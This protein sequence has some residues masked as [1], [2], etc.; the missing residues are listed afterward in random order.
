MLVHQRVEK[1]SCN[2]I[3]PHGQ[4]MLGVVWALNL[5]QMGTTLYAA[6]SRAMRRWRWG[7][8]GV[9][10]GKIPMVR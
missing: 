2:L 5:A 6:A 4:D 7:R 9:E 10:T 1:V 8:W 3:A